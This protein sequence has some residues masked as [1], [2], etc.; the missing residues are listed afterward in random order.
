MMKYWPAIDSDKILAE[1]EKVEGRWKIKWHEMAKNYRF[2]TNDR[3]NQAYIIQTSMIGQIRPILYKLLSGWKKI[4]KTQQI[5][6][7]WWS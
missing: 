3:S 7:I 6:C 4:K 5:T 2:N 1:S